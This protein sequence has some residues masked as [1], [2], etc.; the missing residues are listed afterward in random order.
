M[1]LA[2]NALRTLDH[3]GVYEKIRGQGYNYEELSF[4]N[5]QGSTLAKFLNGSLKEYHY[6]ALR[7]HRT[8]V[9]DA[10]R[11][12]C[13]EAGI[14]IVYGEKCTAVEE[15]DEG[16]RITFDSGETVTADFVV[17]ADGIHSKVR[18]YVAPTAEAPHFSGL[19]GVMG[20][21]MSDELEGIS[22]PFQLP[23]MLY[24]GSGFFAIMPSSY[25]GDEIGYFATVEVPDRSREEWETLGHDTPELKKMLTDRFARKDSKWPALVQALVNNAPTDTLTCWP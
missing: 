23:A 14:E 5:G 15:E 16:V 24:G 8:I 20:K 2:P 1:A 6:Q 12:R 17:G 18:D 19:M 10:L 22:Y 25:F 9:R 11:S 13:R 21:V 7:I 4:T 3:I